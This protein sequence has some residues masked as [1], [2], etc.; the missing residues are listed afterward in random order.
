MFTYLLITLLTII[1]LWVIHGKAGQ[2]PAI[3]I[4]C[5]IPIIGPLISIA[6][7]AFGKWN[8]AVEV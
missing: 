4:A 3:S 2:N 5:V 7:L 8:T 6:V 1:P